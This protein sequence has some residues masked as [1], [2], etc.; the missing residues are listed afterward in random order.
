M[1]K[2]FKHTIGINV[3]LLC[4]GTLILFLFS[5]ATCKYGF[6]DTSPIPPEIKTFRVN[7]LTNKA[8]Y[9]NPQLSP[10]LTEKLKQ[11][12]INTTRLRQTNDDDAH[13]D[14]SGYVSQYY[15]STTG[16]SGNAASLNRLNVAFHLVFKNVLDEKKN[17]EADVAYNLD[18]DA[19]LGLTQ[20]ESANNSK[21]VS[22][23]VDQ[24][25]NKIFS[26]W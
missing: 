17:F 21:M 20:I 4:A 24:I 7:Y 3:R 12:I 9:V 18:Y 25:F 22:N 8:Q 15:T 23:I 5:Y 11:K 2:G 13:Y 14:I 1:T 16:V 19:N 10:Q 26:N 6:K